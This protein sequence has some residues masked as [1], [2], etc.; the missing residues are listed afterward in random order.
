MAGYVTDFD[1]QKYAASAEKAAQTLS[2]IA[3]PGIVPDS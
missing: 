1:L 2:C 3:K